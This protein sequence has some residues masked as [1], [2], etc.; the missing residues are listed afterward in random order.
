MMLRNGTVIFGTWINDQLDGKA[1]IFTSFGSKIL[2]QFNLGKLNGWTIAL[3][4]YK[5][6]KCM[7]YY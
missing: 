4:G 6:I 7:K 1:L 2:S 5:I 3:Y